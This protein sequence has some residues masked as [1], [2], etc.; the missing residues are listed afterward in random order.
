MLKGGYQIVDLHGEALTDSAVIIP[1]IYENIEGNYQK[2]LLLS[3]VHVDGMERAD[4]FAPAII[5]GGNFTF[6]VYGGTITVTSDDAV[7][8]TK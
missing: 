1:G 3:G 5:D 8:Y 7:T 4:V 6:A 2:P